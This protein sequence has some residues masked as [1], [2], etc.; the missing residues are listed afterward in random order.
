MLEACLTTVTQ[1]ASYEVLYNIDGGIAKKATMP[2]QG[3]PFIELD[4]LDGLAPV[5]LEPRLGGGG[6]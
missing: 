1:P 6:H 3:A 2:K 4:K 5:R